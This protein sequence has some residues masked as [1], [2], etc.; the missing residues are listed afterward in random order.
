MEASFTGFNCLAAKAV[1]T[2]TAATSARGA[3][4][5]ESRQACISPS[6]GA[7]GDCKA[8]GTWG[9]LIA[10]CQLLAACMAAS[11]NNSNK[12]QQSGIRRSGRMRCLERT[13][14]ESTWARS[15]SFARSD[16]AVIALEREDMFDR[17]DRF[18]QQRLEGL[19]RAHAGI[20]GAVRVELDAVA[21]HEQF[22]LELGVLIDA[23]IHDAAELML[24]D[25][26]QRPLGQGIEL[27]GRA[28][29]PGL[30]SG[31]CQGL[32]VPADDGVEAGGPRGP[33]VGT[34]Y[35][36]QFCG[37]SVPLGNIRLA[38]GVNST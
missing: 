13:I 16:L 20:V 25:A 8:R 14:A 35:V 21:G 31:G 32:Q 5:S 1:A 36:L 33:I 17:L 2:S 9:T 22:Q 28:R 38:H 29:Q 4:P 3:E 27:L 7:S 18:R 34:R 6:T 11:R 12:G 19:R 23:A 26:Q 24:L 15:R 30:R 37:N 10:L